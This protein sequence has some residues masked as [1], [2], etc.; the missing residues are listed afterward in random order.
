MSAEKYNLCLFTTL[1]GDTVI[2]NT[3]W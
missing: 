3:L 2:P 1:L